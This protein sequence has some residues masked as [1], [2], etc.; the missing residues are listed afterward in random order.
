MT[1]STNNQ[2][3]T[4]S[5]QISLDINEGDIVTSF[6]FPDEHQNLTGDEAFYYIGRVTNI[7]RVFD[8]SDCDRYKVE[9]YCRIWNGKRS[10]NFPEH[11]F[12]PVNGTPKMLTG[13]VT[14]GVIKF[15]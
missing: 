10:T 1:N 15:I 12:P 11:V 6:D 13:G 7:I 5:K 4:N 14:C 2:P 3:T 8:G 9:V